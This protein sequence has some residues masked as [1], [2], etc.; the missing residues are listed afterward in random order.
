MS[1]ASRW[2]SLFSN[3]LHIF[4]VSFNT[5]SINTSNQLTFNKIYLTF[6]RFYTARLK[7]SMVRSVRWWK[8][9]WTL[10]LQFS[11]PRNMNSVIIDIQF[12]KSGKNL[13]C[14]EFPVWKTIK[15]PLVVVFKSPFLWDAFSEPDKRMNRFLCY[16]Y[17]GIHCYDGE[18]P[19][20]NLISYLKSI[21][22]P[23]EK[24][25]LKGAEK[26]KWL[27][28]EINST[29]PIC[30]LTELGCPSLKNVKKDH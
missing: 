20:E 2:C 30:D 22:L 15:K 17:H 6:N 29:H 13:L 1:T 9:S 3:S 27:Q 24:I 11:F 12:F 23:Y 26:M 8:P 5:N 16:N 7:S 19:Y 25:I 28:Q 10:F 4:I 14:K 21:L 18:I